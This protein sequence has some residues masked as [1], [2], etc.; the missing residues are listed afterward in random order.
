[1]QVLFVILVWT[2]SQYIMLVSLMKYFFSLLK[3]EGV[4]LGWNNLLFGVYFQFVL[5]WHLCYLQWF[6]PSLPFI[7]P[8]FS[9]LTA[10]TVYFQITP[11]PNSLFCFWQNSYIYWI[12]FCFVE[13]SSMSVS[14]MAYFCSKTLNYFFRAFELN[15]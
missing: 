7:F 1:M 4:C 5:K 15:L 2:S 6:F 14:P 3:A 10:C 13:F 11:D 9:F 12:A 8:L